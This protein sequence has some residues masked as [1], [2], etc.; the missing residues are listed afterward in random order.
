MEEKVKKASL[1]KSAETE[2]TAKNTYLSFIDLF[3]GIDMFNVSM[4]SVREECEKELELIESN[5]QRT[6]TISDK[7]WDGHQTLKKENAEIRNGFGHSLKY[8]ISYIGTFLANYHKD[9]SENLMYQS[10]LAERPRKLY[11]IEAARQ[12]GY[13]IDDKSGDV[14]L[15]ITSSDLRTY[16]YFSYSVSVS[17]IKTL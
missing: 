4:L 6:Y 2:K 5:A 10:I 7:L 16:N 9:G 12:K 13:S 11:P 14:R 17:F 15:K 3:V 8:E 1:K